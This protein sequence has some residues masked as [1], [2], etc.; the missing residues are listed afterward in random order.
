MTL[1]LSLPPHEGVVMRQVVMSV[2]FFSRCCS[3]ISWTSLSAGPRRWAGSTFLVFVMLRAVLATGDK[4]A[5]GTPISWR[6]GFP[7]LPPLPR[8]VKRALVILFAAIMIQAGLWLI[9]LLFAQTPILG[10]P[11]PNLYLIFPVTHDP[12]LC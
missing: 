8:R 12:E 1:S 2:S 6:T 5:S 7:G 3:D 10:I 9:R 11:F 4:P